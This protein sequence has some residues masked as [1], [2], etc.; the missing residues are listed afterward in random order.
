MILS[1]EALQKRLETQ[2]FRFTVFSLTHQGTYSASDA[3]WNYK[4]IPHLN[5]VHQLV[6]GVP[7]IIQD[8]LISNYFLQ[9]IGPIRI[10][11]CVTNY[12]SSEN[13][14]VYFTSA[15]F[16]VII[17]RTEWVESPKLT[18]KV[19]T[20]YH[21]GSNKYLKFAHSILRRLLKRNYRVL[22]QADVPM[23]IQRGRLREAG[24]TFKSDGEGY[25]FLETLKIHD[26]NVVVP[27]KMLS[28]IHQ[29]TLEATSLEGEYLTEG[30]VTAG[31]RLV[32]RG[33]KLFALPKICAHEGADL[34]KCS[35]MTLSEDSEP[36][37]KCPWHGRL[38]KGVPIQLDQTFR[39]GEV[40]YKVSL[41]ESSHS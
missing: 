38:V 35:I 31:L 5:E 4:D 40:Q 39:I 13:S 24:Y 1:S 41:G 12:S 20:T 26:N 14:Q 37:V 16:F 36:H 3:D 30:D 29:V 18:T 32:R 23:R 6:D 28:V 15:L 7:V 11:L 33:D 10:P 17:I 22:M 2:G 9:R 25:S 27:T 34:T 19:T 21:I 8:H